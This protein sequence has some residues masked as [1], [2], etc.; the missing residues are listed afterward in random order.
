M[1]AVGAKV[2]LDQ[3]PDMLAPTLLSPVEIKSLSH[4]VDLSQLTIFSQTYKTG[5]QPDLSMSNIRLKKFRRSDRAVGDTDLCLLSC[6]N[7]C[8]AASSVPTRNRNSDN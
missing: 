6:T 8:N 4:F 5:P 1:D 7:A 3:P 2:I